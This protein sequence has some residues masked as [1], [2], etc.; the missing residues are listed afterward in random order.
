MG[1]C[2]ER[3]LGALMIKDCDMTQET[4]HCGLPKS[5]VWRGKVCDVPSLDELEEWAYDSGC[6]TPD[7]DW[8]EP[9]HPDSWLRILRII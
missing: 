5:I 9:D 3:S 2:Q 1:D 4:Q 8:V 6:E 7:G